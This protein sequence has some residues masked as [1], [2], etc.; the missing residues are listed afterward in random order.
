ML[1]TLFKTG[2]QRIETIDIISIN[3]ELNWNRYPRNACVVDNSQHSIEMIVQQ[4]K[5][6]AE[7]V[8]RKIIS[9][10]NMSR[11]REIKKEKEEQQ[12]S[13]SV[14]LENVYTVK[15]DGTINGLAKI[16]VT[17]KLSAKI[18]NFC[19]F[20]GAHMTSPGPDFEKIPTQ[21]INKQETLRTWAL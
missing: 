7:F 19:L 4:K 16:K 13:G 2:L 10:N 18:L 5:Y 15:E 20:I 1:S 14:T 17:T 6:T 8:R 12:F 11:V 3:L 9:G 21:P